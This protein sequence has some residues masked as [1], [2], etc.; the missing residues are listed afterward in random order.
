MDR[1]NELK[2]VAVI[3]DGNG[4]W[5][6]QH[7]VERKEGHLAGANR[8]VD[9]MNYISRYES[10]RYV[11]LYAFSTENWKGSKDEVDALMNILARFLD[12]NLE[13]LLREKVRLLTIG[14]VSALPEACRVR[15]DKVKTETAKDFER[16]FILALNYGSRMEIAD[17]AKS[18]A[19]EV[20]NGTLSPDDITEKTVADHLYLPGIPDPDLLIRTSGEERVSN[21]LLWQI[22]YSEF[23]FTKTLWPDFDID[24]FDKAVQAF[25]GRKR[26]FGGR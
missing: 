2:H 26:R 23:Y 9:F 5:A 16:T 15:L 22:S 10:I 14:D 25:Y 3:L 8:V 20:K 7:G 12:D 13:V 4:R 24:E 6:A 18:I 17:A 1:A 11:T 21:F 19:V